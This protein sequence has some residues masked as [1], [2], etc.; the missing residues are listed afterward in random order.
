MLEKN[1]EKEKRK[2]RKT[3][4]GYTIKF[5]PTKKEKQDKSRK[6]HKKREEQNYD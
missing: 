4:Q 2:Q 3:W 5:T 1:I 6:K